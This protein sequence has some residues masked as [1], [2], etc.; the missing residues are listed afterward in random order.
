[1]FQAWWPLNCSK[2]GSQRNVPSLVALGRKRKNILAWG[3]MENILPWW[4]MEGE[5]KHHFHLFP[6]FTP[7][8]FI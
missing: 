4:P 1:M 5:N 6:L 8:V 2:F 3:S 7:N